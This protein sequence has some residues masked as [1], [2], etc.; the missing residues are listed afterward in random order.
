MKSQFDW[1]SAAT[2]TGARKHIV[3]LAEELNTDRWA[4][5]RLSQRRYALFTGE[6]VNIIPRGEDIVMD[7]PGDAGN[8]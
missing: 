8:V 7:H 3:S 4:I 6:S 1:Q 5:V 2:S